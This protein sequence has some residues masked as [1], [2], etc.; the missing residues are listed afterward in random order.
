MDSMIMKTLAQWRTS[1]SLASRQDS[2]TL[3]SRKRALKRT[4]THSFIKLTAASLFLGAV[5]T[6]AA[7]A[8]D[9]CNCGCQTGCTTCSEP[10]KRA[11]LGNGL[12]DFLDKFTSRGEGNCFRS[13]SSTGS[14]ATSCESGC[15]SSCDGLG[16]GIEISGFTTNSSGT[17]DSMNSHSSSSVHSMDAGQMHIDNARSHGSANPSPV[18]MPIPDPIASPPSMPNHAPPL[19]TNV[20]PGNPFLD[21]ARS[22]PSPAQRSGEL[23]TNSSSR[24]R[25]SAQNAVTQKP[26]T[27]ES[28]SISS[29]TINPKSLPSSVQKQQVV[30][31]KTNVKPVS[32]SQQNANPGDKNKVWWDENIGSNGQVITAGSIE[33][34]RLSE[35]QFAR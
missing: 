18:P 26:E 13:Q 24:R 27:T 3:S 15:S 9:G 32:Q 8:D 31:K 11:I 12:L 34:S 20:K 30:V 16:T 17:S 25:F 2:G 21:E 1:L 23:L 22:K 6:L 5:P 7:I 4:D 35:A 29:S 28:L 19:P 14:A 33:S 10:A